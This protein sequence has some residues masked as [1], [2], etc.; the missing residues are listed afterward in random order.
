MTD[1]SG[2]LTKL[3]AS[4]TMNHS[5]LDVCPPC[6]LTSVGSPEFLHAVSHEYDAG[7]LCEGLDDVEIAQGAHFEKGHSILLSIGAGL[8]RGHLPLEGQVQS[9]AH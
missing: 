1:S 9:V 4:I 5:E 7:Q 8:L 6:P 2:F 3:P